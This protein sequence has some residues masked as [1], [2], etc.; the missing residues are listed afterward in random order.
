[1]MRS[2]L[3][4]L[5]AALLP[6]AAVGQG[7]PDAILKRIRMVTV[8]T[9]DV[10]G[11]QNWYVR[12]LDYKPARRGKISDRMAGAWGLLA[13]GGRDYALLQPASGEDVYI[14]LAA[15]DRPATPAPLISPGWTA[16][17]IGVADV[18]ASFARLKNAGV[19]ILATPDGI[20]VGAIRAFQVKGPAGEVVYLTGNTGDRL[21]S[22]HPELKSPIDRPFIMVMCG[23]S[24]TELKSFYMD[25]F[26][27]GDQGDLS[28]TV[29]ILND[30]LKRPADTKTDLS[31]LVMRERGNKLEIDQLPPD[32]PERPKAM[33][34][35]PPGI[36]MVSFTVDDISAL[37]AAW[38]AQPDNTYGEARAGTLSGPAGE[39]IELVEDL[40]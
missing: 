21:K 31:V 6:A 15:I 39:L 40:S 34:Q 38:R 9:P 18:D 30:A 26:R 19:E 23:P 22:N 33:G 10:D 7:P 28:L 24:R 12:H 1:M 37:P 8:A 20:G 4:A 17:E 36:A 27:L 25:L 5:V 16:I 29:R 11:A 14:R 3:I 2:M 35:F 32:L 13:M